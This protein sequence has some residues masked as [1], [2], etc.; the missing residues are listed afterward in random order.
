MK[1]RTVILVWLMIPL[2]T[3]VL[4]WVAI[5]LLRFE[6]QRL[7]MVAESSMRAEIHTIVDS[8]SSAM[9]DVKRGIM[10]RLVDIETSTLPG[11]LA[12]WERDNPLIR[13]VF[14]VQGDRDVIYP[15]SDAMTGE[16]SSF[17]MRYDALLTGRSPW[18][19]PESE[20]RALPPQDVQQ[21]EVPQ[22]SVSSLRRE[23]KGLVEESFAKVPAPVATPRPMAQSASKP[24]GSGAAGWSGGMM[25]MDA[26][27]IASGWIPWFSDNRLHL[28]GWVRKDGYRY[29]AELEMM[30][31][32]SRIIAFLP[33]P[34]NRE[35]AY[36]LVDGENNVL[37]QTGHLDIVEEGQVVMDIP[38]GVD[39]PHWTFRVYS[40]DGQ[41]GSTGRV[42]QAVYGSLVVVLL[43]IA[44]AGSLLLVVW[45]T[46]ARRDAMQKT[47]FVSN[48]SH[49]LKT[50]L[51]SIRMYA[52]LL[53]DGRVADE[54]KKQAYLQTIM[55][56]SRRLTRLVNNVLDFS[57]LEQS[58]K[59][60]RP[61]TM[62]L[63]ETVRG[64]LNTYLIHTSGTEIP[65]RVN[66]HDPV[67]DGDRDALE[68]ILVNLLD[69]AAKYAA[70]GGSPDVEVDTEGRF[71]VVRVRDRGPG[72]GRRHRRKIFDSFY[73]IDNSLT[74]T[75]P[76]SG[77]GLS[78]ARRLARANGGDLVFETRKGG[79]SVFTLTMPL[80]EPVKEGAT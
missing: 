75:S 13:N 51:T 56:E 20:T 57:R 49:E 17:L 38:A 47:T 33:D 41:L 23:F 35:L 19:Q 78:I 77:L 5:R 65:F 3:I 6:E 39:L 64:I 15:P 44:A 2:P 14:V 50:P 79:G 4:G 16:Q 67:V 31:L 36:A 52:E 29:G 1:I 59:K 74:A 66:S 70:E 30:A 42:W 28:L 10:D 58:R 73:R 27:P 76:G 55:D 22:R 60:V 53:G 21:A 8:V 12:S 25:D 54:T 62:S 34:A 43:M 69:N 9:D 63:G 45:V 72:I 37:H 46:R 26:P 11:S 18:T 48:V 68:Q 32:L 7:R 71:G 24:Q 80:H 40:R 61:E